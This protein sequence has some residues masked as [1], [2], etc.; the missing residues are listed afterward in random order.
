M[1]RG[2]LVAKNFFVFVF[3]TVL[4]TLG[5]G[6]RLLDYRKVDE[7]IY[8]A[9]RWVTALFFPVFPLSTLRIK[10]RTASPISLGAVVQTNY[11]FE[12][13]GEHPTPVARILRMYLFGWLLIPFMMAGPTATALVYA[14]T[15]NDGAPSTLKTILLLT[16][17]VWGV[18]VLG[19]LNHR[20]EKL[21]DWGEKPNERSPEGTAP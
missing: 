2:L 13:L 16:S 12:L 11:N 9:T 15:A 10:P 4:G 6:V 19:V 21:Y 20:K 3:G 1:N 5:F 7:G 18:V 8:D 17:I 14:K